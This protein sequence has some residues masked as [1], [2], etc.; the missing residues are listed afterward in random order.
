MS[1]G[2]PRMNVSSPLQSQVDREWAS[3]S[4]WVSPLFMHHG[5]S[6]AHAPVV[7]LIELHASAAARLSARVRTRWARAAFLTIA[8]AAHSDYHSRSITAAPLRERRVSPGM[9]TLIR[10]CLPMPAREL[11]RL[12]PRDCN[13]FSVPLFIH[14]Y[15]NV[16]GLARME[17]QPKN[18]FAKRTW[19][20]MLK[21]HRRLHIAV[22]WSNNNTLEARVER[23]LKR[24][25]WKI[26]NASSFISCS[27]NPRSLIYF[28]IN[29]ETRARRAV[30]TVLKNPC[31]ER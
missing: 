26:V 23:G 1:K 21:T 15:G 27:R 12:P 25:I 31:S 17:R 9:K 6:T 14:I 30:K 10:D 11:R 22:D 16:D 29:V 20:T 5:R 8:R 7:A 3:L 24:E 4:P 18:Q 28:V 2:I 19:R 13:V